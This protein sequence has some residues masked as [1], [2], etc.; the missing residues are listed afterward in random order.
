MQEAREVLQNKW[1]SMQGGGLLYTNDLATCI[2]VSIYSP[3]EDPLKNK[4]YLGHFDVSDLGEFGCFQDMLDEAVCGIKPVQETKIWVGGGQLLDPSSKVY[5][6]SP[7]IINYTNKE[8]EAFS[9]TIVS[10][11]GAVSLRQSLIDD[12]WLHLPVSMG[13][14]LDVSNGE[15]YIILVAPEQQPQAPES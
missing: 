10:R 5:G 9:Q 6:V 3:A 8:T 7:D 12:L 11:L 14:E 2:G 4:A 13:Y 1:A 15:D